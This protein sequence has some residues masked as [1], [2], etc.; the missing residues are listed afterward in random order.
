M[1]ALSPVASESETWTQEILCDGKRPGH[2]EQGVGVQVCDGLGDRGETVE[3]IL[4]KNRYRDA[5]R[6]AVVLLLNMQHEQPAMACR[7]RFEPVM[8]TA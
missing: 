3:Q 7:L 2:H 5:W 6:M 1:M 4:R 8:L